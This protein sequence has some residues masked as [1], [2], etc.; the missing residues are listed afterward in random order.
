MTVVG[1]GTLIFIQACIHMCVSVGALPV[2]GQ[3]LPFISSGGSAY[4]CMGLA[5]GVIQSVAYDVN[6]SESKNTIP[7]TNGNNATSDEKNNMNTI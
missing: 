2:T 4:L 7:E 1:L 3:T 5:L 6:K